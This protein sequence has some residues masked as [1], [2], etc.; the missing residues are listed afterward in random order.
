VAKVRLPG[1]ID[2]S[3]SYMPIYSLPHLTCLSVMAFKQKTCFIV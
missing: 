2:F 3:K 1:V